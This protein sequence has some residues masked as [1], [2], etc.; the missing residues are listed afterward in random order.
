MLSC[1]SCTKG[2]PCFIDWHPLSVVGCEQIKGAFGQQIGQGFQRARLYGRL[3]CS[4]RPASLDAGGCT[5]LSGYYL[6]DCC[7]CVLAVDQ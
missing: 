3:G 7:S 6:L 4:H 5:G 2:A 1:R